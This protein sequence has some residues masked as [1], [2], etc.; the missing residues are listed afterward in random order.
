MQYKFL[1]VISKQP[2][3]KSEQI[4]KEPNKQETE[5]TPSADRVVRLK[6]KISDC[7][8]VFLHSKISGLEL[9]MRYTD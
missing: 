7:G 1:G 5:K 8:M 4:E 3:S 6:G 2:S 9:G